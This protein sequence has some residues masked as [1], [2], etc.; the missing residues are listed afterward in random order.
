MLWVHPHVPLQDWGGHFPSCWEGWTPIALYIVL[1]NL[2]LAIG[3]TS[4]EVSTTPQCLFFE[5]FMMSQPSCLKSR[6]IRRATQQQ[7]H[8]STSSSTQ[9]C[10]PYTFRCSQEHS[11]INLWYSSLRDSRSIALGTRPNTIQDSIF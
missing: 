6:H 1:K 11:S 3:S 2:L 4:A 7:H 10:F 9:F 8:N 5:E